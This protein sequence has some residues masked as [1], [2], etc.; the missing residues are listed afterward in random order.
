MAA[1][2]ALEAVLALVGG[3]APQPLPLVALGAGIR[4]KV[5]GKKGLLGQVLRGALVPGELK[6]DGVYQPFILFHEPGEFRFGQFRHLLSRFCRH[7]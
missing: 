5:G 6:A 2:G 1:P 7:L 3:D 4:V